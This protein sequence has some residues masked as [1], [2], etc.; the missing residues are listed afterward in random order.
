M[1][2]I[3]FIRPDIPPPPPQ[4]KENYLYVAEIVTIY[5]GNHRNKMPKL[6]PLEMD[7]N[8]MIIL[9]RLKKAKLNAFILSL[10]LKYEVN[11]SLNIKIRIVN[12]NHT[13]KFCH[14]S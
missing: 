2:F 12:L 8:W 14:V 1:F 13:F 11:Y 3:F 5:F 10:N 9:L 6:L 4:K 7:P